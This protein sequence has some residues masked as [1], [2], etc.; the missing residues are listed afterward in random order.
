MRRAFGATCSAHSSDAARLMP[1]RRAVFSPTVI[2]MSHCGASACSGWL[3]DIH[4][5]GSSAE[6]GMD[7]N[8]RGVE[9]R[10][11]VPP[12]TTTVSMPA[13]MLPAPICTALEAGRAVAVVG[14]A[15]HA[16]QARARAAT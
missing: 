14:Q 4:G 11:S 16:G 9:L 12:A 5:W 6:A 8:A 10:L 3:G 7:L 1:A 15:G 13:R 2:D